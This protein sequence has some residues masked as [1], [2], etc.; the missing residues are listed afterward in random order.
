MKEFEVFIRHL[1]FEALALA[2]LMIVLTYVSGASLWVLPASF[3]IFDIGLIGY[4]KSPRL[5]AITYNISHDLTLPT[6]FIATGVLWSLS[7]V[8]LI[9][10]CWAFHI[11]VDRALG[12]GLKQKHSFNHTHLG[13]IGKN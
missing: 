9:G 11:A 12:F 5:G 4:I 3:L 13:K 8:A 1:K 10:F 7:T 2:A 6:L